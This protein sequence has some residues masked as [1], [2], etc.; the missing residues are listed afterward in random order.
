MTEKKSA[1]RG[2]WTCPSSYFA[3]RTRRRV[4][5]TLLRVNKITSSQPTLSKA[6]S[7]TFLYLSLLAYR[8]APTWL[9]C[10]DHAC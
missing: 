6:S 10:V 7:V 1:F 8:T 5:I 2:A 4:L 9:P 3:L